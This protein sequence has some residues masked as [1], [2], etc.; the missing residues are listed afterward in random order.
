MEKAAR[1]AIPN[2]EAVL[3]KFLTQMFGGPWQVLLIVS[4]ILLGLADLGYR[5]G[6]RLCIE[7]EEGHRSLIAGVQGA[8][9]GLLALLLGFTF[10]MCVTR[11]DDRRRMIVQEA[12]AIGTVYLRTDLL[13]PAVGASMKP[14]LRE[15]LEVRLRMQEMFA[16]PSQAREEIRRSSEIETTVWQLAQRAAAEAPT[17][18]TA[19]FV[20]ALNEMIDT[21]AARLAAL[22]NQIPVSVWLLLLTVASFGCFTTGYS[23]GGH[24]ARSCFA[25]QMLP[26]L[27]AIVIFLIHDMMHPG[28]GL[29]GLSEQPLLDLQSALAP[30][31]P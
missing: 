31:G 3:E 26:L 27:I 25:M 6:V 15:Y 11:H 2:M 7:R 4:V 13:P 5:A 29:V 24:R 12:N 20:T 1:T 16:H 19:T 14:L 18:I 23:A 28:S 10:S 22:R 8:V 9:L 21:D 30:G 17:P